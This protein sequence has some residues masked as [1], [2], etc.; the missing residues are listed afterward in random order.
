MKELI[1]GV[2]KPIAIGDTFLYKGRRNW[3]YG[4]IRGISMKYGK[5][6]IHVVMAEKHHN[7]LGYHSTALGLTTTQHI[8]KTDDIPEMASQLLRV[9]V[10][11]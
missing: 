6:T 3:R 10:T 5:M 11:G 2:G 7:I 4:I 8:Y 9:R 1:D